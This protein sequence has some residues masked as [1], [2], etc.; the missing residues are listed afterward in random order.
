[1]SGPYHNTVDKS[2]KDLKQAEAK[3]E[4]QTDRV[5]A[6]VKKYGKTKVLTARRLWWL[7]SFDYKEEVLLT[8]IRR[9]ISDI[10][11]DH[12][13]IYHDGIL[14]HKCPVSGIDTSEKIIKII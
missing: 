7:Y 4:G 8:S 13:Y 12:T 14:R 5:F 2:G 1:M 3:A 6:L 9:A 11:R 10:I